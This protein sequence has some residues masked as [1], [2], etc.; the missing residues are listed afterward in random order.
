MLYE[1]LSLRTTKESSNFRNWFL[2]FI[3]NASIEILYIYFFEV[4]FE[5]VREHVRLCL[6]L[7][8]IQKVWSWCSTTSGATIAKVLVHQLEIH[9]LPTVSLNLPP[10]NCLNSRA[11]NFYLKHCA[12]KINFYSS[13]RTFLYSNVPLKILFYHL[14]GIKTTQ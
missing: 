10:S 3:A 8:K 5:L 13:K 11:C 12:W 6:E 4:C 14:E 9:A 1:L 7:F 2:F